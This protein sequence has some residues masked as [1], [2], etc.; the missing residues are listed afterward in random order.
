MMFDCFIMWGH[1]QL[2]GIYYE[3]P[4]IEYKE[5]YQQP[6]TMIMIASTAVIALAAHYYDHQQSH[7][8]VQLL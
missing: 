6:G 3:Y 1:S 4:K 5:A 2:Q 7:L 8:A